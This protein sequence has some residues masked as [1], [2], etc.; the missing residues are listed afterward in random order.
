[1]KYPPQNTAPNQAEKQP[2]F[3]DKMMGNI[4]IKLKQLAEIEFL[5][6]AEKKSPKK[7]K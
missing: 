6:H 5:I 1:M 7:K 3:S 2:F 4:R